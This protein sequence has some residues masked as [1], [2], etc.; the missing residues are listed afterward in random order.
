M[1][2][3]L[4]RRTLCTA[5]CALLMTIGISVATAG[6]AIADSTSGPAITLSPGL[7]EINDTDPSI[8]Y[9]GGWAYTTGKDGYFQSDAHYSGTAGAT[10]T[11]TFTGT[12]V[13]W[14]GGDNTDHG[15]VTRG[16][17][18]C[19]FRENKPG[20]PSSWFEIALVDEAP[21]RRPSITR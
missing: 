7:T 13:A 14:I 9:S 19:A 20:H 1:T 15:A 6:G 8:A 10:A 2:L 12:T 17:R 3:T 11:L 18:Q 16:K 4:L 21:T 5:F